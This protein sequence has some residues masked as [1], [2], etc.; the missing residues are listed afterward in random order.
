MVV[1]SR[2][3]EAFY[4]LMTK[5]QAFSVHMCWAVTF[6]VVFPITGKTER[7]E[8][9]GLG[10]MI[11]PHL[12]Y[13]SDKVL[14]FFF[15]FFSLESRSFSWRTLWDYFTIFAQS[16]HN[17]FKPPPLKA[18]KWSFLDHQSENLM[19]SLMIKFQKCFEKPSD[20]S[21]WIRHAH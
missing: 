8:G 7:W 20:C 6:T 4:N 11:F 2:C 19:G 21:F 18:M 5:S 17:F 15:F 12:W 1:M 9:A 14:W 16:F 3:A 13:C 10:G